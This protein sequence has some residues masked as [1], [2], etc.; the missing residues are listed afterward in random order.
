[1]LHAGLGIEQRAKT[2]ESLFGRRSGM[3]YL[4]LAL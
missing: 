3:E 2:E 4:P 1:M